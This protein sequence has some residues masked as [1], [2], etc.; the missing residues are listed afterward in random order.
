MIG[1]NPITRTR[2][3]VFFRRAGRYIPVSDL[4]EAD[5]RLM[6]AEYDMMDLLRAFRGHGLPC[7]YTEQEILDV[8]YRIKKNV[9]QGEPPVVAEAR[10]CALEHFRA[11]LDMV[12]AW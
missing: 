10:Q 3:G 1:G 9:T 5:V 6:K 4:R 11:A 8:I 12:R 2:N 7:P